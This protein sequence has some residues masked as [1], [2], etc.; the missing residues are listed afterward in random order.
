MQTQKVQPVKKIHCRSNKQIVL[1]TDIAIIGGGASGLAA[2]IEAKRTRPDLDVLIVEKKECTGKKLR[3]TGNGRCNVSNTACSQFKQVE[4]W[5]ASVGI[6]TRTDESG[7][8]Y[9][10]SE[11]ASDVT[12]EL[13]QICVQLG[14][15]ILL[16]TCITGMEA[17]REGG[18][19]LLA[20]DGKSCGPLIDGGKTCRSSADI[21]NFF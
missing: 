17:D 8:V 15:K 16:N 9:P 13:T 3:A 6:E 7:R 20:D 1:N 4:K 5:F 19:H 10:Y 18:F 12:Q 11:D 2:A 21:G 14:V